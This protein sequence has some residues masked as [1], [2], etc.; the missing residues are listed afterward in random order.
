MSILGVYGMAVIRSC[1]TRGSACDVL[2]FVDAIGGEHSNSKYHSS[3]ELLVY[4]L[5]SPDAVLHRGI[6]GG[7]LLS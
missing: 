1:L 6:A 4:A 5:P 2:V 7:R 3:E